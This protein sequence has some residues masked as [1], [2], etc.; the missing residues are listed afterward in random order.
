[1][2]RH[3]GVAIFAA[4]GAVLAP[5]CAF[6]HGLEFLTAKLTLLP[7]YHVRV[8]VTADYAGNP[9]VTDETA[10]REAVTNPLHVRV[11]DAWVPLMTMGRP[12]LSIH[13]DWASCAPPS[14]PPPPDDAEHAL[15][16]ATWEWKH[17]AETVSFTV[18][19]GNIHDVFLW[20]A[21]TSKSPAAPRWM[22]LLAGDVTKEMPLEPGRLWERMVAI[23]AC[24][25]IAGGALWG[26]CRRRRLAI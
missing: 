1:M 10:A 14:L 19:K 9:L 21:E 20:Q 15:V 5:L 22:L 2:L 11:G 26:V 24:F 25:M 18:P 4:G 6:G 17:P 3:F 23:F 12:V 13:A 16:T 7:E 8:E